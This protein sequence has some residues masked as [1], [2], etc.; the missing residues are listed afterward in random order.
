MDDVHG[1]VGGVPVFHEPA[2]GSSGHGDHKDEAKSKAEQEGTSEHGSYEDKGSA[3]DRQAVDERGV[4]LAGFLGE[5]GYQ[6]GVFGCVLHIDLLF[7]KSSLH[8]SQYMSS[9]PSM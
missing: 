3:D 1:P 2:E 6:Q 8:S 5:E 7:Q 4:F 9:S